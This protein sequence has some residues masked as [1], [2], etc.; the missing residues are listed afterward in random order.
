VSPTRIEH[1]VLKGIVNQMADG[2]PRKVRRSYIKS[3]RTVALRMGAY[4]SFKPLRGELYQAKRVLPV[5]T[6]RSL[7]VPSQ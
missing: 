6:Q 4:L 2:Q 7:S 1:G 3:F 5:T